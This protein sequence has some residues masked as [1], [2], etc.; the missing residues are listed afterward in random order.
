MDQ[1]R[2]GNLHGIKRVAEPPVFASDARGRKGHLA[3]RA[4]GAGL[5]ALVVVWL[6]ALVFGALGFG[7]LPELPFPGLGDSA[8]PPRRESPKASKPKP[9]DD[10]ARKARVTE[11]VAPAQAGPVLNAGSG[12]SL[13]T[14]SGGSGG[15]SGGSGSTGGTSGSGGLGGSSGGSGTATGQGRGR[16]AD[17]GPRGAPDT[18][19]NGKNTP[20]SGNGT[21]HTK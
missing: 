12:L 9:A 10:L 8:A 11:A 6:L 19:P 4:G 21:T 1:A 17:A 13:R 2:L 16:P 14:G 15:G 18:T 7:G 3:V 5:A 20:G